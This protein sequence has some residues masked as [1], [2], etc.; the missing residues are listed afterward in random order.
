MKTCVL[1]LQEPVR[2]EWSVYITL[3]QIL[4]QIQSRCGVGHISPATERQIITCIL[5]LVSQR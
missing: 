2:M 5:L 3:Y 4:N 1:E